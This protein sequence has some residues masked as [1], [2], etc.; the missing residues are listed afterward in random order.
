MKNWKSWWLVALSAFFICWLG[1]W[2]MTVW[3]ADEK[4]ELLAAWGMENKSWLNWETIFSYAWF[5]LALTFVF[6]KGYEGSDWREGVRFGTYMW[7]I[8]IGALWILNA[9]PAE[10]WW[11]WSVAMW[12]GCAFIGSVMWWTYKPTQTVKA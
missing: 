5:A 12:A 10:N 7:S 1:D 8:L 9:L 4:T 11:M 6:I 2:A 3:M